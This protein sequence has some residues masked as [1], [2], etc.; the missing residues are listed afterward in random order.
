MPS[1]RGKFG[2]IAAIGLTSIVI[3][4]LVF[5]LWANQ[6]ADRTES[7]FNHAQRAESELGASAIRAHFIAEANFTKATLGS[8]SD[9][10][11]NLRESSQ[12][13]DGWIVFQTGEKPT[14]LGSSLNSNLGEKPTGLL[15]AEVRQAA[16]QVASG[17]AIAEVPRDAQGHRFVLAPISDPS[18]V[19]AAI[20]LTVQDDARLKA[21][22]GES[23]QGGLQLFL[24]GCGFFLLCVT[25]FVSRLDLNSSS[26]FSASGKRKRRFG[27]VEVSLGL[28]L[29]LSLSFG[30]WV[31]QSSKSLEAREK[32][33]LAQAM[34]S[35]ELNRDLAK[36]ALGLEP[37]PDIPNMVK[38]LN[39]LDMKL[40][41]ERIREASTSEELTEAAKSARGRLSANAGA[42][43]KERSELD[44]L[45]K[46]K[47]FWLKTLIAITGL[48]LLIGGVVIVRSSN[49]EKTMLEVSDQ[50]DSLDSIH[51][52]TVERLPIGLFQI[53]NGEFISANQFFMGRINARERSSVRA[54]FLATLDRQDRDR[55][56]AELLAAEEHRQYFALTMRMNELGGRH[57]HYECR[58]MPVYDHT[59][60][61]DHLLCFCVDITERVE[62]SLEL[63]RRNVELQGAIY[64][65]NTNIEYTL[66]MLVKAIEAKDPY[67]A[68][69]SERVMQFS[70]L[71]GRAMG[72]SADELRILE[73][74][75]LV[76]D[77]G[78]IGIPDAILTKPDKLTNEEF[79]IVKRHPDIGYQMLRD[80]PIFEECLPIIRHHHEKLDGTGYPLGLRGDELSM[81]VRICT[82]ADIFDALTSSRS[83]RVGMSDEKALTILTEEAMKGFVDPEIV[84]VLADMVRDP[85]K[86]VSI[87]A[88]EAA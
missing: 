54:N 12:A 4:G 5:A 58:G 21:R 52:Q 15:S 36:V 40:D 56:E 48:I 72:L 77:I 19:V 29:A 37:E 20:L 81:S 31:F 87:L 62:Q 79:E 23:L 86:A 42:R 60:E 8:L 64:T 74:G 66:R 13:S 2:V 83:Y 34:A 30:V 3:F 68:G 10:L 47:S 84:A 82:V 41:G 85:S 67:T 1:L 76:H 63:E 18:G 51:R 35:E 80:I 70:V 22:L 25:G 71:L 43:S 9:Q 49:Q 17:Q 38:Q 24:A 7:A 11:T 32:L 53:R 26:K 39:L 78:K 65:I 88:Q 57:A 14:I 44:E 46:E 50:L 45:M 69:H 59:G 33:W 55:V 75:A 73:R 16:D 61:F 6:M 27:V 28:G